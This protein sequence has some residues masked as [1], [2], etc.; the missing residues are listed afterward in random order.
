MSP[1][2]S[3]ILP[4]YNAVS[5]IETAV[6]SCLAQTMTDFELVIVDDGST[7]GTAERLNEL[8]ISDKRIRV[9]S[10][11][12]GGVAIAFNEGMRAANGKYFARMDS[13]D[14]MMPARLKKQFQFLEENPHIGLVSSLVTHGGNAKSQ[15]GYGVYINWINSLIAPG[16]IYAKRFVESPVANPS[17]MFRRELPEKSGDCRNGDFPE[18]YELWLRWL[19]AG[20]R[21]AKIPEILLKWNDPPGRLTRIDERYAPRAFNRVKTGYLVRYLNRKVNGRKIWLCG[22]GRATRRKSDLLFA[23]IQGIAGYID[24]D[25]LKAN[26][27]Y[28]NLPVISP[29]EIPSVREAYIVSYVTNRGAR[30]QIHAMLREKGFLEG[31]DFILAG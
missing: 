13:D 12:H 10:L 30:E 15:E 5:S 25:P 24:A 11:A 27:G 20:V 29:E 14:E 18:D 17:V 6:A 28:N 7:D 9:I 23:E 19:E 16:E 26:R 1:A 4:V 22:A 31:N 8:A 2:I 3:I 21:M